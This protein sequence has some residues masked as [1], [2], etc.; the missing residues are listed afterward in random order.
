MK[1][2]LKYIALILGI[3]QSAFCQQ[4][5]QGIQIVAPVMSM[6]HFNQNY[7]LP[8][9]FYNVYMV[10]AP[11]AKFQ[12]DNWFSVLQVLGSRHNNLGFG[13]GY[14]MKVNKGRYTLRFGYRMKYN[15]LRIKLLQYNSNTLTTDVL[16]ERKA[17]FATHL[18]QHQFPVNV[19]INLKRQ[20]NAPYFIVGVEPGYVF[21]KMESSENLENVFSDRIKLPYLNGIL[22]NGANFV[23]TQ[24]GFGYRKNRFEYDFTFKWRTDKDQKSLLMKEYVLDFTLSFFFRGIIVQK[25]S[26][27]YSGN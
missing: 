15:L 24:I 11:D 25:R 17:I 7:Y 6:M 12:R 18:F 4:W 5:S 1:K 3:W 2:L 10:N 27:I 14:L 22:Y 13:L 23:W 20:N 16:D 8:T 9:N 21:G 19:L 26:F